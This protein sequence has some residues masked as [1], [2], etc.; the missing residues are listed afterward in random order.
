[1]WLI[2]NLSKSNS[3]KNVKTDSTH[4]YKKHIEQ[5]SQKKL[6]KQNVN[7]NTKKIYSSIN[8]SPFENCS[9]TASHSSLR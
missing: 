2:S 4:I 3:H 7:I 5:H 8:C 6:T 9:L 1:M